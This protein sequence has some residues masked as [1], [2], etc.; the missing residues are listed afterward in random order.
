MIDQYLKGESEQEDHVIHLL[1]SANRWEAASSILSDLSAGTTVVIDRYYYSGCVYSAAKDNPSLSLAWSRHPEEGLPRPDIC[2][3]LD[4]SA[5]EAAKR[6]DYGTEKYESKKM[7]DRVRELFGIMRG[8]QEKDDFVT[9]DAGASLEEVQE[10][11]WVV[12]QAAMEKVDKKGN[13]VGFVKAWG[14]NYS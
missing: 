7:Q 3:F 13:E 8:A 11:V 1:F 12:V 10:K 5:E 2:V 9:V 6:G 4:I 14:E